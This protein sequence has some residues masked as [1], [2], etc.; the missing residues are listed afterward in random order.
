MNLVLQRED[1][2]NLVKGV[3][4]HYSVMDHPI[5]KKLGHY[6]GGFVDSWKWNHKF[7]DDITD[8]ELWIA[9]TTCRDSFK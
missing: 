9:Y 4:P 7:D 2:I 5:I 8:Q 3:E 1:L 6:V